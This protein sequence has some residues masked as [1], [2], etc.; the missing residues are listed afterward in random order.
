MALDIKDVEHLL[1][2]LHDDA[3]SDYEVRL[4]RGRRLQDLTANRSDR[5]RAELIAI[6]GNEVDIDRLDAVRD[7]DERALAEHMTEERNR[8]AEPPNHDDARRR[9]LR[10]GVLDAHQGLRRVPV[11]A[12]TL[13]ARDK[14]SLEGNPGERGNPWVF[15]W[16]PGRVKVFAMDQGHG[17]GCAAAAA[18]GIENASVT[19]WFP[20]VP[21]VTGWW[22][23]DT[24]VTLHGYR[25]LQSNGGWFTCNNSSARL[26][27][28]MDVFQYGHRISRRS[29]AE[30]NIDQ[31]EIHEAERVDIYGQY[32]CRTAL[33]GGDWVVVGL[34]VD[35]QTNARGH[36]SLSEINFS[37]GVANYIEPEMVAGSPV[38]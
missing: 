9:N 18:T 4:A 5:R 32:D 20:F 22:Y 26:A 3:V 11:A 16:N 28:T 6:L 25:L 23:L 2:K 15:P 33:G 17:W 12:A 29:W 35:L 31:G 21:D 30:F 19:F 13:L 14:A 36:H 27:I 37:D 38:R 10:A 24:F 34:R 8:I 7:D 1:R